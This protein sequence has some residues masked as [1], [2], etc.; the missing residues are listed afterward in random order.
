MTP[1]LLL[2][3]AAGAAIAYVNGQNDV[4]KG[5]ATLIGSGVTGYR[6][7]VLWGSL[8]T[9]VGGFAGAALAGA[10]LGTFGGGLL[11]AGTEPELAAAL[12]VILGAAAWVLIATR[13][14]LPVS[15]THAIVGA[16]CGV[17]LVAFGAAG[18]QWSAVQHKLALPLLLGPVAALA[19]T[20]V[21]MRLV[22]RGRRSAEVADCLCVGE[23][24]VAPGVVLPGGAAGAVALRV[25]PAVASLTSALVIAPR[26]TCADA[27]PSVRVTIDHLHWLTSGATSFARGMNDA[28]KIVALALAAAAMAGGGP[29]TGAWFAIVV[30]AMV[31]GSLA[32]GLRVTRVLAEKVT[33]M[34]H[35]EGFVANLVTS[36]LVGA[37][38]V[39]G[40]PL[41]T[42]HVSTGAIVGAGTTRRGAVR[43]ATVR[44]LL[45]AWVVTLPLAAGLGI[46]AYAALRAAGV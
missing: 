21:L 37:G 2:V 16:L 46:A 44:T 18:V 25:A 40:L 20:S 31:G 14:G 27:S 36:V 28:P 43:W 23:P 6:R 13:T 12:A 8:W 15:T 7:A 38:A 1:I 17:G 5:I 26:A 34:D 41:S 22:R 32:G 29:P 39:Y 10:M 9:G 45:A 33:R 30:V 3:V 35:Q 24:V 11:A 4:S 19:L 42:T